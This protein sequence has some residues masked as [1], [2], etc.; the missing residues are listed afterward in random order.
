MSTPYKRRT[1]E[2]EISSTLTGTPIQ[3]ADGATQWASSIF[4]VATW[5]RI[6]G[7]L[8]ANQAVKVVICFG[9]IDGEDG[10]EPTDWSYAESFT[11]AQANTAEHHATG[12]STKYACAWTPLKGDTQ[13]RVLVVNGSGSLA[14]IEHYFCGLQG[15]T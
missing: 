7:N 4:Q 3:I 8:R 13:A 12:S 14:T 2:K 15:V 5:S 10:N 6:F 1:D 11:A 9:L